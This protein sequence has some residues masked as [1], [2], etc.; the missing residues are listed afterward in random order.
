MKC[1][2]V[3]YGIPERRVAP[4]KPRTPQEYGWRYDH[5]SDWLRRRAVEFVGY[6][7]TFED[8]QGYRARLF[9]VLID[10]NVRSA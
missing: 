7:H 9:R 3:L 1:W 10:G 2:A 4:E 8:D 5:R 6:A